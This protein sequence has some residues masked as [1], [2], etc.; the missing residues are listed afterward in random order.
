MKTNIEHRNLDESLK[1]NK[2]VNIN[3]IIFIKEK[4]KLSNF[5]NCLKKTNL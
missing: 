5:Y 2:I 3:I 4:S 1:I